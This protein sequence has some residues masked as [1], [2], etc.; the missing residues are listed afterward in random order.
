MSNNLYSSNAVDNLIEYIND[1]KPFHS[2]LSEIVEEYQFF[3]D[4]N[5]TIDDSRK[6]INVK[7]AG[8]WNTETYSNGLYPP[9]TNLAF[10]KQTKSSNYWQ[11][12]TKIDPLA[13]DHQIPGMTNAYYLR[14]NIGVR[15][16]TKNG[17][18][19]HEGIDFH[20]THGAYTFELDGKNQEY[21]ETCFK[22]IAGDA[23]S[24]WIKGAQLI[25]EYS[26]LNY[27][28]VVGV[29][30]TVSQITPNL[31]APAY[32][33]WTLSCI[34]VDG[35]STDQRI[36]FEYA[37]STPSSS[38]NVQHKL[39]T[40]DLFIQCYIYNGVNLTPI[41]PQDIDFI[42]DNTLNVV[43]S[44][45]QTG[46]IKII[47]YKQSANMFRGLVVN[48]MSSWNIAHNLNTNQP[49]V[50]VYANTTN[51]RELVFP[52][53]IEIVDANTINVNFTTPYSGVV[54]V[55]STNS[56][57]SKTFDQ[58]TPSSTW[59]IDNLLRVDSGIF[60]VFDDTGSIIFPMDIQVNKNTINIDFS[61]PKSGKIVFVKLF[62]AGNENTIFSV[63]G[64]ESG[65]IGYAKV[66]IQ[67]SSSSIGFVIEPNSETSI[68][69]IGET[70]VLTPENRIVSHK[71]Y[72]NDE[73]WSFVK[74]NPIAYG[75]PVFIKNGAPVV[76][77]FIFKSKATRPQ[78]ITATFNGATYDVVSSLDGT[79]GSFA[80]GSSISTSEFS[81]NIS[82]GS[83]APVSGDY[84]QINISNDP[85]SLNG[86][87]LTI[88][89]DL[90]PYDDT[91]YDDHFTNFD[92]TSLGL[93]ILDQSIETS[94]FELQFNGVAFEVNQYTDPISRKF[95]AKF[96]QI[97]PGS[98]YINSKFSVTIPTTVSYIVGDMFTFSVDNPDPCFDENEVNMISSRFGA[99]TLYPKSFI[100][101]PAQLWTIT[102]KDSTN[103]SVVGSLSGKQSDGNVNTSYDNGLIH[104]SILPS[105]LP[106]T[107]GDQFFISIN[108]E[109]PSYL[110]VGD[111]SGVQKPLTVGKWYW[112]GK[113]G[114]KV[115][116]PTYKIHEFISTGVGKQ[117][118]IIS[119]SGTVRLDEF[120]NTI[121]F[122]KP[123]RFDTQS[124]VYRL[125]PSTS[126]F[127][128]AQVVQVFNANFGAQRG[129]KIGE[130]YIDD[131]KPELSRNV[132]FAHHDGTVDLQID[133][134][135]NA[136]P[137]GNDVVF[138]VSSDD[139]N[140]FHANDLIVFS[141]N[142]LSTDDLEIERE[143]VD[144][145]FFKTN[146]GNPIL[147][148][149]QDQSFPTYTIP[150]NPF[151]DEANTID[152]Y[153]S[154]INTKVGTIT[155]FG[156]S[157]EQYRFVA[158]TDF[159]NTFLPF[160]STISTKIIQNE[161]EN[162]MVNARITEKFKFFDYFR[163]NDALN[164]HMSDEINIEITSEKPMFADS[165]YVKIDD[166]TFRGFFSG[167]DTAPYDIEPNGYDDNESIQM[168][169]FTA[170]AG[171]IGY[172]IQ[173]HGTETHVSS[174]ISDFL[175][176]YSRISPMSTDYESSVILTNQPSNSDWDS[177]N[178][179]PDV[180]TSFDSAQVI[181]TIGNIDIN[182][183]TMTEAFDLMVVASSLSIP[184][185]GSTLYGTPYS[186]I[187]SIFVNVNK[188]IATATI[189]KIGLSIST[190]IMYKDST[191]QT[192]VPITITE[193]TDNYI[194]I[195]VTTPSDGYLII[196]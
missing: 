64:S 75:K 11:N 123:P 12:G 76:E 188:K 82:V 40:Q 153:A 136:L 51:G 184:I 115:E 21:V 145:I 41:F 22:N 129:L 113:I 185:P 2:K 178:L 118:R 53:D 174:K 43:F 9:F 114:A 18:F 134:K 98:L 159:F 168:E 65:L 170:S 143:S 191:L 156:G 52:N 71:S 195:S 33:E 32:E 138:G 119:S 142:V 42:D 127:G 182:N 181:G 152:V 149:T 116:A 6:N 49:V 34:Q 90:A 93:K 109:K 37:Q 55:G 74:V 183:E 23:S 103:F 120:G 66:G 192:Q 19:L 58:T 79:L 38:W 84:F 155:N 44:S 112:N 8:V 57:T 67:F 78:K 169:S 128:G 105:V 176:V 102:M 100:D 95:I 130:R 28:D 81:F 117:E 3:E 146:T 106:L 110:V 148:V 135:T 139:F 89:Y 61:S 26:N 157:T 4:L 126:T 124:D 56:F 140:L 72:T 1:V 187:P 24:K 99:I 165:I 160:N 87:D 158:D 161:Q 164:V 131:M 177:A 150:A 147:G 39:G 162:S 189:M 166:S 36:S 63:V 107:A 91:E 59:V 20:L 125:S 62:S 10:I 133:S 7:V 77:N 47:A 30:G 132:G 25:K 86:L 35:H 85:P 94:Y 83:V 111:M 80:P 73:N 121:T 104:F 180:T 151:S 46:K 48:E 31:D 186:V 172:L 92:I 193:Q 163:F 88:G 173:D 54:L 141:D 50:A 13:V 144:K 194:K 108:D 171:G 190:V 5:V 69:N 167:Y 14:H 196:F 154:T 122:N 137:V 179:A 101:S 16:A 45:P 29:N 70:F 96:N 27:L 17:K 60:M 175:T 15:S 68:F 97:A